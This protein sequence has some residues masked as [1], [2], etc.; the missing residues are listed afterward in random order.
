MLRRIV[1]LLA[2]GAVYIALSPSAVARSPESGTQQRGCCSHHGGVSGSCCS[3]GYQ[4]C[5]DGVCSPS[6][7]C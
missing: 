3:N 2:A 6:C 1:S 7:R 5:N 4:L